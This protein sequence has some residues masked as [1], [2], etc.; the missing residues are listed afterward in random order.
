[1]LLCEEGEE[2]RLVTQSGYF[3]LRKC[4]ASGRTPRTG[5]LMSSLRGASRPAQTVAQDGGIGKGAAR[6]TAVRPGRLSVLNPP[7]PRPQE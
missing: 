5:G 6:G 2:K 3:H 7:A 1:M 4:T